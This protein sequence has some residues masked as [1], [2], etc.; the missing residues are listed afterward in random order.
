MKRL[1][2]ML[3]A[4][5][6]TP[7]L[8]FG[9]I[10]F[11]DSWADGGRDNGADATDT[12]WYYSTSSSAIEVGA[13]FLGMVSG[14]SGRGIHGVF[15][16]Q[17]LNVG[18]TL[19][20]TIRFTTPA[21]IGSGGSSAFRIG[22]F[23]DLGR[24]ALAGDLSASS[25][26]PNTNYWGVPGYMM[27]LDVGTG[28]EDIGFRERDAVTEDSNTGRLMSTTSAFDSLDNGGDAYTFLSETDYVVVYSLTMTGVDTL[29]L[30]GSLSQGATILSSFSTIDASASTDTFAILAFNANSN[31]FGSTN[32]VDTPDNG[33]DFTN[34]SMEYIAI[35]E[36]STFALVL[37]GLLVAAL[38]RRC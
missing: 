36:P 6:L 13:G 30:S 18:D 34:I 8:V 32:A 37:G 19:T 35:P 14:T 4:L 23:D 9:D 15:T 2:P 5:F 33:L 20:A 12:D 38:R 16:P 21:T 3:I 27:D 1:I 22:L 17:T 29:Q 24:A 11:D 25:G 31:M 7:T 28:S 26:S 10:V